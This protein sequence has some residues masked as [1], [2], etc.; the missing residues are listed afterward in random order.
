MEDE[1]ASIPCLNLHTSLPPS[2][3]KGPYLLQSDQCIPLAFASVLR[4]P[5]NTEKKWANFTRDE[6][7]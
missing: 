4:Y 2:I 6:I 7:I 3:T 5:N 1:G